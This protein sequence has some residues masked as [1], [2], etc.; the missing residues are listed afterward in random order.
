MIDVQT[1]VRVN[2]TTHELWLDSR[3]SLLDALRG[4]RR[5]AG[6]VPPASTR[7][8]TFCLDS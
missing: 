3:L 8:G 5:T 7:H 2:N 6:H 1:T 4:V